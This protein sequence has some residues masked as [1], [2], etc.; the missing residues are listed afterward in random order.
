[1]SKDREKR[2]EDSQDRFDV[3]MRALGNA[4]ESAFKSFVK[5]LE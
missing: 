3:F 1:M 5:Q 2:I 4:K